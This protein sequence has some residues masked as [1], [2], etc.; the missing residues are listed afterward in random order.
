MR[1]LQQHSPAHHGRHHAYSQEAQ[2]ALAKNETGYAEG[3]DDDNVAEGARQQMPGDNPPR[4]RPN[5]L[6]GQHV[7]RA[8]IGQ[9]LAPHH[10]R[11]AA[12][13]EEREDDD[14]AQVHVLGAAI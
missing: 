5:R 3:G 12:P 6:R 1:I 14:D 7:L 11:Q 10:P 9:N 2:G 8:P 4:A 13:A